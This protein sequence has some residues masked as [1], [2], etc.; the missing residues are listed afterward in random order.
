MLIPLREGRL[1]LPNATVAEVIGYREPDAVAFDADWLQ[2]KVSWPFGP[3][4]VTA[5]LVAETWTSWDNLAVLSQLGLL[6][7]L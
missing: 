4:Q 1:L 7:A 5:G 3:D 2:G 6:Q